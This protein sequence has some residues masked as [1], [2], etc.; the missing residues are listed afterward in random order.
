ML[1]SMTGQGQG[2][3]SIDAARFSVEIRSVNHRHLKIQT[4]VADGLQGVEAIIEKRL[5][6]QLRRGAVQ[7][8]VQYMGPLACGELTIDEGF[9]AR[10]VQELTQL[11]TN[12]GLEP[13]RRVVDLLDFPGVV[14][15]TRIASNRMP[16]AEVIEGV[17]AALDQAL[18]AFQR[19]REVEGEHIAGE[20]AGQVQRLRQL[21][22]AVEQRAPVVVEEYQQRLLKKLQDTCGDQELRFDPRDVLREV[23]LFADRCDIREEIVR[24][25][26]HLDQFVEVLRAPTSQGRRLDFLVQEMFR[27]ANTIGA[28]ASDAQIAGQVVEMKTIIEQMREQ[29]QNVE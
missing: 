24:L 19:M 12:L 17:M 15:D 18:Q 25:R 29:I 22:D 16:A 5:R 3:H 2:Q 26:S 14:P 20:L 6:D 28:K 8:T 11:A 10:V 7:V 23:V 21:V 1:L 9:L 27:E 13:P 4:R